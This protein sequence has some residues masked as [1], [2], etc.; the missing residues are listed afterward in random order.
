MQRNQCQNLKID[1]NLFTIPF[2]WCSSCCCFSCCCCCCCGS[3][4]DAVLGATGS[5]FNPSLV[6]LPAWRWF[7]SGAETFRFG[8]PSTTVRAGWTLC[9]LLSPDKA[10]HPSSYGRAALVGFFGFATGAL[11]TTGMPPFFAFTDAGDGGSSTF[12]FRTAITFSAAS[13][14]SSHTFISSW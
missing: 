5:G 7:W 9:A 4:V 12:F 14:L 11:S 13:I 10:G 2:C 1:F 8:S 6:S 3:R